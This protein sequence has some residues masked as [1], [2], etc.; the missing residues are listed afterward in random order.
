M[1]ATCQRLAS[2]SGG[3]Q[4]RPPRL[5]ALAQRH[6]RRPVRLGH[7]DGRWAGPRSRPPSRFFGRGAF[8]PHPQS[9][10]YQHSARSL[11]A[12]VPGSQPR[13]ATLL[14][15]TSQLRRHSGRPCPGPAPASMTSA[16]RLRILASVSSCVPRSVPPARTVG[17]FC[18]V[19]LLLGLTSFSPPALLRAVGRISACLGRFLGPGL[20]S[21]AAAWA[22]RPK[23]RPCTAGAGPD[24]VHGLP[25]N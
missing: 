20:L 17:A 6:L 13:C 14:Q 15:A 12:A 19:P 8:G 11:A 5:S 2:P 22:A 10:V 1:C 9:L 16:L 25:A 21:S 24:T 23:N 3:G 7:A 18:A 4:S